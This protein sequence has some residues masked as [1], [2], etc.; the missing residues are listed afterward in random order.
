MNPQYLAILMF[1]LGANCAYLAAIYVMKWPTL[2][3]R[4][5]F[6][7][8]ILIV[9]HLFI[10]AALYLNTVWRTRDMVEDAEPQIETETPES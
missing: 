10:G 3:E 6:F 9:V 5:V 1:F 2:K 8:I 4:S 7:H